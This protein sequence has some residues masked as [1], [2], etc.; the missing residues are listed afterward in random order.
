M[1][2]VAPRHEIW[3]TDA[4]TVRPSMHASELLPL[5]RGLTVETDV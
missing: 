4:E 1:D 5:V 2:S 3:G